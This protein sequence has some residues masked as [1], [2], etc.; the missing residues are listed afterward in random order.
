MKYSQIYTFKDSRIL[1]FKETIKKMCCIELKVSKA[2]DTHRVRYFTERM[3]GY[4]Q[5]KL[6]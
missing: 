1:H 6:D 2:L 4:Y 3:E 5:T